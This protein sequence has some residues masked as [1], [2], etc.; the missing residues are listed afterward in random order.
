M[1]PFQWMRVGDEDVAVVG[2]GGAHNSGRACVGVS[3]RVCVCVC[4]CVCKPC[5]FG[6]ANGCKYEAGVCS[7]C[8]VAPRSSQYAIRS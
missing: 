4:V 5:L 1:R 2:R 7:S 6:C 3:M 8:A